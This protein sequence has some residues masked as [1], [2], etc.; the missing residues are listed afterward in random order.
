MPKKLIRTGVTLK[1]EHNEVEIIDNKEELNKLFALKVREE[2]AEIQ[3]SDHKDL[4]E[5]ADLY[6]VV[7]DFAKVN[8]F[9]IVE[10]SQAAVAKTVEKGEFEGYALN[11]LNPENPSNKLYFDEEFK[12]RPRFETETYKNIGI[13]LQD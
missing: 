10:L 4:S 13:K 7:R 8:G 11:N 12:E 2:L 6:Q 1:L 3:A 9:D 5:F